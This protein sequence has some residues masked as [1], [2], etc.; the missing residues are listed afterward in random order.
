MFSKGALTMIHLSSTRKWMLGG[1]V[2]GFLAFSGNFSA[3]ARGAG[4]A[5]DGALSGPPLMNAEYQVREPRRCKDLNAPPLPEQ[6]AAVIQ[7]TME[8]NA[9]TGMTLLRDINVRMG[10]PRNFDIDLDAD[11]KEID[12]DAPVFPL[13]GSLKMY[14]CSPV[15]VGYPAGK[16]C[17]LY[18]TP[19][20]MGK[21]WKTGFG[22]WK[23]NLLGPAPDSRSGV[24]GPEDY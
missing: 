20:A 2:L 5:H 13:S 10:A 4:Q 19:A 24:A 17:T 22:D 14:V 1:F 18:L 7:C 23:C 16:S 11:L 8:R 9:P 6:V 21:C 12:R 3:P 15:G